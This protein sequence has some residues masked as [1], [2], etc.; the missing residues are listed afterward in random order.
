MNDIERA[1]KGDKEAFNRLILENKSKFY[2]TAIVILKNKQDAYDAIQEAL[3]SI[4]NNI[5]KLN[6]VDSF[7]AWSKRILI[8]KCYDVIVKNKKVIDINQKLERNYDDIIEDKYECEDE[9]VIIL[10]KL[11][12]ELRLVAMFYYYDEMSINE[13]SKILNIPEGTVKSRLARA[14]KKLYNVLKQEGD[15]LDE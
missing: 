5:S 12:R 8:N 14:R 4:Y 2:K 13:I 11:D 1:Q 10:D 3:L 7:N 15:D 9:I 6:N